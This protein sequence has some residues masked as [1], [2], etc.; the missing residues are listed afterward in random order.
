MES[1]HNSVWMPTYVSSGSD[2]TYQPLKTTSLA[3]FEEKISQP[4][5]IRSWMDP[6]I[7]WKKD[8]SPDG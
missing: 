6:T 1:A 3:K 7:V 5:E 4:T 8:A 2:F